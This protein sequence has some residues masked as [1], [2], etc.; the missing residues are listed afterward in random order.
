MNDGMKGPNYA[1]SE[2]TLVIK[3]TT[4]SLRMKYSHQPK[5]GPSQVLTA[6]GRKEF[7]WTLR[8]GDTQA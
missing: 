7:H 1:G 6:V 8:L 5:S 4:A 3:L 2:W